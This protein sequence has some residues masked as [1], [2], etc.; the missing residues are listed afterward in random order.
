MRID[1][2]H[3]NYKKSKQTKDNLP[4][5]KLQVYRDMNRFLNNKNII[6]LKEKINTFD[7]L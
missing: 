6:V 4:K 7:I 2:V 1:E 3:L 5:I